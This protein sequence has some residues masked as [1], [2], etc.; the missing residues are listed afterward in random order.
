MRARISGVESSVI[1]WHPITATTSWTPDLMAIHAVR[2]AALPD[3]HATSV[4]HVGLGTRPRY[5]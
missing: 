4:S 2:M 1:F 5:S 3:A